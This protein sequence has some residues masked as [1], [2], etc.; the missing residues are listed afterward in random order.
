[1]D[2]RFDLP[3]GWRDQTVYH[4]QGPEIDGM[5]HTLILTIDRQLL[6]PEITRF[7]RTRID[8]IV[9]NLQGLEVLKDEEITLERGNPCY[10]FVYKWIPGEGVRLFHKYI[11]VIKD[12][13]GFTASCSFSKRSY[14]MLNE[15][16]KAL[17]EKVLPGT[18]Q[19][20]EED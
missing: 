4:F 20:L 15:Q 12:K 8:P 2:F 5:P 17:V 7:S 10:E 18:Y 11:F 9:E 3:K 6:E 16:M 14:Q 1:M 13:M 19:P